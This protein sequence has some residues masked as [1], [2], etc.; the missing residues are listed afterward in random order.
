MVIKLREKYRGLIGSH[1]P[2]NCFIFGTEG[3]F[4]LDPLNGT[5]TP[6]IDLIG[7]LFEGILE[8]SVIICPFIELNPLHRKNLNLIRDHE[9]AIRS[10]FALGKCVDEDGGHRLV[11]EIVPS[12]PHQSIEGWNEGG[13]PEN[14]KTAVG[15]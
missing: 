15:F 12:H 13:L 10:R 8:T 1:I 2:F 7:R 4:D 11:Q 3:S 6:D 5:L 9:I 14:V